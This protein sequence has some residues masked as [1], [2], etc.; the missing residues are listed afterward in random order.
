M[1]LLRYCRN[2]ALLSFGE[3]QGDEEREIVPKKR[4]KNSKRMLH[5][6]VAAAAEESKEANGD[7]ELES[8]VLCLFFMFP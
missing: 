7:G 2:L 6:T 5:P 4:K 8:R 1:R 3:E